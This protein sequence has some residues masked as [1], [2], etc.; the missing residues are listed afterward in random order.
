MALNKFNLKPTAD[1][2]EATTSD[3]I[4]YLKVPGKTIYYNKEGKAILEI[5]SIDYEP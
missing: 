4:R 2:I 5:I 3:I 1:N